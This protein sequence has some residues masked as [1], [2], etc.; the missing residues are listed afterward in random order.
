MLATALQP[1]NATAGTLRS[2][3]QHS[4]VDNPADLQG[5]ATATAA[6]GVTAAAA[7]S[8][9]PQLPAAQAAS[10]ATGASADTSEAQLQQ[11]LQPQG[12][13][14][15]QAETGPGANGTALLP[16]QALIA[17]PG[18][19]DRAAAMRAASAASGDDAAAAAAEAREAA[20]IAQHAHLQ[21]E[22]LIQTDADGAVTA[23]AAITQTTL[24]NVTTGAE[25]VT[26]ERRNDTAT[27]GVVRLLP[28]QMQLPYPVKNLTEAD[29]RNVSSLLRDRAAASAAAGANRTGYV[30][31]KK[32]AA[33]SQEGKG[34]KGKPAG[35][36]GAGCRT[37]RNAPCKFFI[38]VSLHFVLSLFL[39]PVGITFCIVS[40]TVS[41]ASCFHCC[42]LSCPV[43][44][45]ERHPGVFLDLAC[46]VCDRQRKIDWR[47]LQ[48]V[49][50]IAVELGFPACS[51][52]RFV[53]DPES[54]M[55]LPNPA[56]VPNF[57]Q[58]IPPEGHEWIYPYSTQP[59]YLSQN[60]GPW[61]AFSPPAPIPDS[62]S[63][64]YLVSIIHE[65]I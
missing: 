38:L 4:V 10:A 64:C 22:L 3:P 19:L 31:P 56:I 16:V 58:P 21:S 41:P 45:F 44:P 37:N 42:S 28:A 30:A 15:S 39:L 49:S 20:V 35:A 50:E 32:G 33:G 29:F 52:D 46:P 1:S 2:L 27:L 63:L 61:C 65:F 18:A 25:L 9:E 14:Q 5:A 17:Y 11:A 36:A 53:A 26:F 48:D 7:Q 47:M 57:S 62:E 12:A 59:H 60:A 51:V 43:L 8:Q 54:G 6:A 13:V 23:A 55:T 40:T 24:G 34:A